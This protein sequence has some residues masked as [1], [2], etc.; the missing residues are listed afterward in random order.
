LRGI[1]RSSSGAF[2]RRAARSCREGPIGDYSQ[3]YSIRYSRGTRRGTRWGTRMVLE[4]YSNG[5]RMVLEWYSMSSDVCAVEIRPPSRDTLSEGYSEEY[6]DGYSQGFSE[7]YSQGYPLGYFAVQIGAQCV[8][9]LH[10]ATALERARL[11]LADGAPG[12]VPASTPYRT[13]RVPAVYPQSTRRVPSECPIG[14]A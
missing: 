10:I 1:P 6:S 9:L 13:L 12:R 7:G 14:T 4:W 11:G 2:G 8:R 5:T 3:G